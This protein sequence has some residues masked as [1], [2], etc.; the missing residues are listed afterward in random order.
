MI[1]GQDASGWNSH[2]SYGKTHEP[3]MTDRGPNQYAVKPAKEYDQISDL[4]VKTT[5]PPKTRIS[6]TR[7]AT[8]SIPMK[9]FKHTITS[10]QKDGIRVI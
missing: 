8:R 9:T 7:T 10:S 3:H 6:K 5:K 2:S 1:M 4:K